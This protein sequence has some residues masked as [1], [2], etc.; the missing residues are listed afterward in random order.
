MKRNNLLQFIEKEEQWG[1]VE[2][3]HKLQEKIMNYIDRNVYKRLF[4]LKVF[5]YS[6]FSMFS[7]SMVLTAILFVNGSKPT[8]VVFIY[9]HSSNISNVEVQGKFHKTNE[10]FPMTLDEEK[11]VWTATIQTHQKDIDDYVINVSEDDNATDNNA[12]PV[13]DSTDEEN[14]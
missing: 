7:I 6:A 10:N 14:I 13:N 1:R 3:P 12:V 8:R 11:G 4:L 5:K 2:T 9:P